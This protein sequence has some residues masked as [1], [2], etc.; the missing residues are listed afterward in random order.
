[1]ADRSQINIRVET[2]KKEKWKKCV[3]ESDEYRSL[4]HFIE[5][6]VAK[7]RNGGHSDRQS[8][9]TDG[10]MDELKDEIAD[11]RNAIGGLESEIED[12]R[13]LTQRA[14]QQQAEDTQE[15]DT[16]RYQTVLSHVPDQKKTSSPTGG[17]VSRSTTD[18]IAEETGYSQS[19]VDYYLELAAKEEEIQKDTVDGV[20]VYWKGD[21]R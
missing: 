18:M 12:L 21:K 1:M 10:E 20:T 11:V 3:D 15:T 19:A 6:A 2:E 14:V 9:S 17:Q 8:M 16:E 5:T 4:T 13:Q 7:E